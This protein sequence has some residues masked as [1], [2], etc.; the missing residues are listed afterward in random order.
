MKNRKLLPLLAIALAAGLACPAKAEPLTLTQARDL[1]LKMHPSITVA[2]LRALIAREVTTETK[3]G[4]FPLVSANATAVGTDEAVTRLSSGTLS[5]SQL[6]DH[7]GVGA[8]VSQL[9]TDFG[10]TGNLTDAAKLRARAADAN[11]QA[12]RAQLL[13]AVDTAYFSALEARAVKGVAAKTLANRQ[14]LFD[15]I[16]ALKANKLKSELEVRFAQVAVDEA[17]ILVDQAEAEWQS[18]LATLSSLLGQR[19]LVTEELVEEP[20]SAEPLPGNAEPLTVLAL[21]QRPDL[22][23]QRSE[24]D[25]AR[26]I[27]KAAKDARLPTISALGV[28]GVVPTHDEHFEHNYAAAGVN[29][30]LPLFAGGL[31][32]A[33]Q[34]EAELQADDVDAA[35]QE[36]ENNLIRDV[37]LAWLQA[38]HARERIVLTDSLLENASAAL[39][40]A[41]IRFEQGLS[42][43][44]ELNQAELS[45]VS[46]EIAH[47][48]AQYDYRMR[49]DI[50]D[51]QTGSLAGVGPRS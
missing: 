12:A 40:L 17:R 25:A 32:R 35:L 34:R 46:A 24:R 42:S 6:Y 9:I 39:D 47:A 10:R 26:D 15:R 33:R 5:N 27:A 19:T 21:H 44:I 8:T 20:P 3:A 41:H 23:G 7:I 50:L 49:R 36:T 14:L 1:A 29:V 48:N 31:Y 13:L 18:S 37:R 4:Y 38:V 28:I 45:Q 11:V 16:N 22:L 30:N 51:Y 43:I 2:K